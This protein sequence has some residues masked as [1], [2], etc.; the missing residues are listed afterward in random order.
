MAVELKYIKSL[1]GET[2]GQSNDG[3]K[4]K[5]NVKAHANKAFHDPEVS[6]PVISGLFFMNFYFKITKRL[7]DNTCINS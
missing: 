1:P 4:Y 5:E 3:E 2:T 7:I 6:I